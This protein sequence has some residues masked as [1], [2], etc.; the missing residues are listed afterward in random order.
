MPETFNEQLRLQSGW[1][2]RI[3]ASYGLGALMAV[4]R[5]YCSVSMVASDIRRTCIQFAR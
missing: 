5:A 2:L 3:R 1:V 4:Y